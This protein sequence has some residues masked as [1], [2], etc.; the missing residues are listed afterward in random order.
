MPSILLS[1]LV[2][3]RRLYD[4][5]LAW[6]ETP[7]ALLALAALAFLEA[8]FFPVPPDVL[9][10][11]IAIA[12]PKASWKPALVCTVASVLGGVAGWSIGAALW[13]GM[14]TSARCMVAG[15]GGFFF[16]YVPGFSCAVFEKVSAMYR[17]HALVA[18]L[19]AAFTPIPFKVF[20]LTAGVADVPLATLV[21]ASTLGR[22]GRFFLVA[23]LIRWFGPQ[24]RTFLNTRFELVTL[25]LGLLLII[26]FAAVR[27]LL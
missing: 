15:G 20:T 2:L 10:I 16:D 17:D 4:W 6:A 26:G 22:G 25:T 21:T 19:T 13:Q 7:Y 5:T 23:L 24:V 14:G 1:P 3:F 9:L 18:L 8:S 27:W 12:A 11:A